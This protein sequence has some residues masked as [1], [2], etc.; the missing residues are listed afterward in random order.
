MKTIF[1]IEVSDE[2]F[3]NLYKLQSEGKILKVVNGKIE[4]TDY[5]KPQE[6]VEQEQIEQLKEQLTKYKYDV[7]Q[8]ELFGMERDDYEL[9][10]QICVEIIKE[11]RALEK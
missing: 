1:G 11:L 5:V 4:A 8:V 6:V 7:E 3:D 9:K 10:K 2:E